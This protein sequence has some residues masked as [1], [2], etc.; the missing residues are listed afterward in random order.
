MSV[1]VFSFS[2]HEI[3]HLVK[4]G[5][6]DRSV[7]IILEVSDEHEVARHGSPCRRLK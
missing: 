3:A 4:E 5:L 7:A 2:F 6:R 1:P